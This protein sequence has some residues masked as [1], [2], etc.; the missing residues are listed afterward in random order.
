MRC[1]DSGHIVVWCNS[2]DLAETLP[3]ACI[4]A[5][6]ECFR[7]VRPYTLQPVVRPRGNAHQQQQPRYLWIFHSWNALEQS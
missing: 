2:Q 6:R 4:V 3:H 5:V 7:E 1:R